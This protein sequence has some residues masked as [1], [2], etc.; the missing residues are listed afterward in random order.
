MEGLRSTQRKVPWSRCAILGQMYKA[1]CPTNS[2]HFRGPWW[3]KWTNDWHIGDSYS[4]FLTFFV[5]SPN[6]LTCWKWL[7]STMEWIV[8]CLA[9]HA[10]WPWVG[11]GG[12]CKTKATQTG[13]R[14]GAEEWRTRRVGG[15]GGWRGWRNSMKLTLLPFWLCVLLSPCLTSARCHLLVV[16][17]KALK[18]VH[19]LFN[20]FPRAW[21]CAAVDCLPPRF[22]TLKIWGPGPFACEFFCLFGASSIE[23]AML[24]SHLR[25]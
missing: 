6:V 3:P 24:S 11:V 9:W 25:R 21:C 19:L 10:A 17:R 23:R 7:V 1:F 22:C 14:W 16:T 4:T 2:V 13:P 18:N 5:K 12:G 15:W 20:F 8:G